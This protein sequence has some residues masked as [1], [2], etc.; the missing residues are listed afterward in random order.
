MSELPE[1]TR[2]GG[3]FRSKFSTNDVP[4]P[5]TRKKGLWKRDELVP[6]GKASEEYRKKYFTCP[7][8]S[9]SL[10]IADEEYPFADAAL[11][12]KLS[13]FF[14]SFFMQAF[15]YGLKLRV[16]EVLKE[17]Y[18]L[19]RDRHGFLDNNMT[20]RRPLFQLTPEHERNKPLGRNPNHGDACEVHQYA[21][22]H[23]VAHADRTGSIDHRIGRRRNRQHETETGSQRSRKSQ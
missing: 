16:G 8:C 5:W 12:K 4:Q 22:S 21:G 17:R 9:S 13:T 7:D 2:R 1:W 20:Q 18:L 10:K 19:Q 14:E 3:F 23:H 15:C 6:F 11:L